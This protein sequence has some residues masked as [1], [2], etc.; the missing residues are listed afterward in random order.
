MNNTFTEQLV[1][2]IRLKIQIKNSSMKSKIFSLLFIGILFQVPFLKSQDL[3]SATLIRSYSVQEVSFLKLIYPSLPT[4]KFGAIAYKVRYTSPDAKGKMDTLSGLMV[5][6][7]N[8][9]WQFPRAVYQH[10]TSSCKT[11]VPSRLGQSGGDE[12]QV[13]ILIAGLGFVAIL[14]D[15]VGMGDGRGFQTYVHEKTIASAGRN[16]VSACEKWAASNNLKLNDQLFI[17]GYS[18]GG[19]GSMALHKNYEEVPSTLKVTAAA[20]LSG[21]YSLS[22]V[23]RDL[24]LSD[25]AYNYPAYIPNTIL[26]F[27]EAYGSLYKELTDIFKPEYASEIKKYY[28]GTSSLTALNAKLIQLLTTNTGAS[29]GSRMI[30]DSV[31]NLIKTNP[32]HP[33]N[34]ILKENDLFRWAPKSP[35]RIFYCMADDQVPFMNSVVARDSLTA[36]GATDLIVTDVGSTLNH[37]GCV[38]PALTQTLSFFLGF[39]RV[40]S[41]T[42]NTAKLNSIKIYPNPISD[43]IRISGLY[44]QG[45]NISVFDGEGKTLTSIKN[46]KSLEIEVDLSALIAGMYYVTVQSSDGQIDTHRIVKL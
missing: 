43:V 39:Q 5:I 8:L 36:K 35:T 18:Q 20:H 31:L 37:G 28:E 3:V 42:N 10:G 29:V 2:F 4:I 41:S 14:P 15:Y 11:C 40:I 45:E 30:K 9:N 21:P 32:N 23:M 46:N 13:G 22:G 44:G 19:Y 7:D 25:K 27:N 12:G 16:M 6:P 33:A 24:I 26:G 17:T 38:N 1:E 34:T